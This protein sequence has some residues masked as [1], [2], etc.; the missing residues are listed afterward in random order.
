MEDFKVNY[1][2]N[3]LYNIIRTNNPMQAI[4]SGVYV[5][6]LDKF[7]TNLRD[8]FLRTLGK[9]VKEDIYY[10]LIGKMPTTAEKLPTIL[11]FLPE[12][13]FS[14]FLD[15]CCLLDLPDQKTLSASLLFT[16]DT[17]LNTLDGK[18]PLISNEEDDLDLNALTRIFNPKELYII[19]TLS[20]EIHNGQSY[21]IQ[22]I[23]TFIPEVYMRNGS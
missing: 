23:I 6:K 20:N 18:L 4:K 17:T 15:T 11:T 21:Y 14:D 10:K 5:D 7:S 2:E 3:L 12:I 19:K 1:I 8:C 13:S 16:T 9:V 22:D